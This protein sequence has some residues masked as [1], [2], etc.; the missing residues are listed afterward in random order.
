MCP[1]R[2]PRRP[3]QPIFGTLLRGGP[4]CERRTTSSSDLTAT[5]LG[6]LHDVRLRHAAGGLHVVQK[7]HPFLHVGHH[8]PCNTWPRCRYA[9]HNS[10]SAALSPI[11]PATK[12]AQQAQ[13]HQFWSVF[14]ALDELFCAHAHTKPSRAKD[15]AHRTK[16]RGDFETDNTSATA[17]T[18]QRE[19]TITTV[20]PSTA[21]I[22]TGNTSATEKHAKNTHFS[23]AKAMTVSTGPPQRPA[24]ATPVSD[25]RS[26]RSTCPLL[27]KFAR[28]SIEAIPQLHLETLKYQRS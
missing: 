21:G 24:K 5:R 27:R 15:F 10:P 6:E 22:E 19:T 3:Q 1:Q 23:P 13:K 7:R 26:A 20:H 9:R 8:V 12:F 17:D 14:S 25:I 2:G 11:Q 18:G 16:R 28:N 4:H